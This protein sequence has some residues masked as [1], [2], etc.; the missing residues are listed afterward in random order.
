MTERNSPPACR[1]S[2]SASA[3][4]LFL[5]LFS[6]PGV[7]ALLEDVQGQGAGAEEFVMEGTDVEVIAECAFGF[8]AQC[9]DFQLPHLV[10]KRLARHDDVAIDLVDDVMFGLGGVVLK[11]SIACCRVQPL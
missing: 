11:K 7:H 4:R 1:A 8:C 3:G 2:I 10:C 5:L 9:F 6:Q